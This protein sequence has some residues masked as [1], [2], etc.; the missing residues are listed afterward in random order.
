MYGDHL[1]VVSTAIVDCCDSSVV[2]SIRLEKGPV[3]ACNVLHK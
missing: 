2:T 1:P 3:D